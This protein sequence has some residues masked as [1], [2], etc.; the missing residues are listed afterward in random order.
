MDTVYA[1]ALADW[2]RKQCEREQQQRREAKRITGNGRKDLQERGIATDSS[3]YEDA[4]TDGIFLI[5]SPGS[6]KPNSSD[7]PAISNIDTT[8]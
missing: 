6:L 1:G 7:R 4:P 5:R 3:E 8:S 2:K